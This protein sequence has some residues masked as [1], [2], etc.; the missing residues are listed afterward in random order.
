MNNIFYYVLIF[1]IL[2]FRENWETVGSNLEIQVI[3]LLGLRWRF[4][5]NERYIKLSQIDALL[6]IQFQLL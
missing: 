5:E 6:R 4:G 3:T 1:S 2:P